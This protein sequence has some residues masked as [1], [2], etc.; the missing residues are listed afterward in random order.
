[1]L[2]QGEKNLYQYHSE[3]K[4]LA[5]KAFPELT[6]SQ[7]ESLVTEGFINGITNQSLRTSI[8][9]TRRSDAEQ[10]RKSKDVL[11]MAAELNEIFGR[12]QG[13]VNAID[14]NRSRRGSKQSEAQASSVCYGCGETG[15]YKY[16]C[17]SGKNPLRERSLSR[18]ADRRSGSV[19]RQQ[20]GNGNQA[21][22]S[23]RGEQQKQANGTNMATVRLNNI[24]QTNRIALYS[25]LDGI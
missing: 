14:P 12:S 4:R 7:K 23:N 17:P 21:H 16:K 22:S 11:E 15:H 2:Q 10:H 13:D 18:G 6:D 20:V 5:G 1:L 8:L 9:A 25:K 3:L 24:E 19:A